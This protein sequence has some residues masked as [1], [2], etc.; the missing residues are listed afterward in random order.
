MR[1]VTDVGERLPQ[2]QLASS[3]RG[4]RRGMRIPQ[5]PA[6]PKCQYDIIYHSAPAGHIGFYPFPSNAAGESSITDA[7]NVEAQSGRIS[8]FAR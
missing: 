3:A 4:L 8:V 1:R 6:P 7:R 2:S 5:C